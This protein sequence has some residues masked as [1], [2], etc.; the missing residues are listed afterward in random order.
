MLLYCLING[1][2]H[3][4]FNKKRFS[5]RGMRVALDRNTGVFLKISTSAMVISIFGILSSLA[6]AN[7]HFCDVNKNPWI[8]RTENAKS[9]LSKIKHAVILLPDVRKFFPENFDTENKQINDSSD[10]EW[11]CYLFNANYQGQ[12]WSFCQSE[13]NRATFS[14]VFTNERIESINIRFQV[15]QSRIIS[16]LE[17][18]KSKEFDHSLKRTFSK[19]IKVVKETRIAFDHP[20][21]A[22]PFNAYAKIDVAG[23]IQKNPEFRIQ[24]MV[25]LLETNPDALDFVM[26]HEIAHLIGLGTG[27]R[28]D[29]QYSKNPFN[30]V[31]NCL[32]SEKSIAAKSLDVVCLKKVYNESLAEMAAKNPEVGFGIGSVDF[33]SC[34]QGQLEE[35]WADWFATEILAESLPDSAT[36]RVEYILKQSA[37]LCTAIKEQ[38]T[39]AAINQEM[40]HNPH[41]LA[42]DRLNRIYSAHPKIREILP[43]TQSNVEDPT[44][45]GKN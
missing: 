11:L 35:A 24:G 18:H 4:H 12:N 1:R 2:R 5:A 10:A 14:Q 42:S 36:E 3:L 15:I 21:K 44:Y 43:G 41:P 31:L 27:F 26:A 6:Q 20:S 39:D 28:F 30:S 19:M 37:W 16:Y 13:A 9:L 8:E 45:C 38:G 23:K 34:Q 40:L 29:D 25:M 17:N 33:S 32:K 22:M 7:G